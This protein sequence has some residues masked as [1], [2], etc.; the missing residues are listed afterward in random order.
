MNLF[1]LHALDLAVKESILRLEE[2]LKYP[3]DPKE[4]LYG[5]Y[6]KKQNDEKMEACKQLYKYRAEL[7][8]QIYLKSKEGI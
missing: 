5:D 6:F 1:A 7:A 4:K 2:Y 3:Y 8:E